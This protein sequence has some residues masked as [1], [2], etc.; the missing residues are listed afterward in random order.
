MNRSRLPL[1]ALA[2]AAFTA[3]AI[4]APACAAE[5]AA[6]PVVSAFLADAEANL[7]DA[8]QQLVDLAGAI[9][10]EQWSW[11]PAEGVRSYNEVTLHVAGGNYFLARM[12]GTPTPDGI[13]S[14]GIDKS[15]TDKAKA[16]ETMKTSFVFIKKVIAGLSEA[17]LDAKV[18]FFGTS[19]TKRGIVLRVLGHAHEHMGQ[20]IAYARMNG[21]VPPWSK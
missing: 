7:T 16:I 21:I 18:D 9:P 5:A 19:V 11:R 13:D 17:D 6:L 20:S 4:A 10:V 1:L 2:L 15:T 12:L 3:A 8:E 14:R